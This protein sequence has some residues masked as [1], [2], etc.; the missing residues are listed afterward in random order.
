MKLIAFVALFVVHFSAAAVTASRP[1][2][3]LVHG[4]FADGSSW[5][6]VIPLLR[7]RRR[8]PARR[9]VIRCTFR[10]RLRSAG[11]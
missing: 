7:G 8:H 2:I 5:S 10:P 6:K 1:T 4:A 11:R 9:E 3:V